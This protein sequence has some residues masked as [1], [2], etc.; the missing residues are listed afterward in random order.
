MRPRTHAIVVL[1]GMLIACGLGMDAMPPADAHEGEPGCPRDLA[2]NPAVVVCEDFE[3][4]S[5]LERWVVGSNTN[6][7]PESEFV[8]CAPG[9]GFKDGCAAWSNY[10]IFDRAWGFWGYDA[11]RRFPP[12]DEF[13]VRWYQYV[14]DP[15]A[16]GT[17]EDKSVLL[18]DPVGWD[19]P[20]TITAYVGTNRDHLPVEPNSGPGIPFVA[21]YQDLDY[22]ETGGEYTKV[23]R[24][25]NQGRNIALESGKWYLFEWYIRLNTPGLSNGVT[26]LW[27]DDATTRI[28]R[29]TLRMQHTDMRWLRASDAGKR[30]GFLRLTVYDQRCDIGV[31]T[32]PPN[33]P[34]ILTQYH[35][36]DDIVVSRKPVGP[37][38]PPAGPLCHAAEAAPTA[39][40]PPDGRLVPVSVNGVTHPNG[41]PV[42]VTI[43]KVTQDEPGGG[44]GRGRGAP[45]AIIQGDRVL[46]RAERAGS[47]DGRVYEVQFAAHDFHGGQCAGQVRVGVPHDAGGGAK[48]GGP[49]YDSTR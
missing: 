9:S 4:G 37:I 2:A 14:S 15:Y 22:P 21:N 23:N 42:T 38:L 10:L 41:D 13:Y 11:W 30:F 33:G 17:L 36:W 29:Q 6:R 3:E 8:T 47:G 25:Q 40:W 7:W 24:F 34:E 18:H 16:W 19:E 45:D 43:L 49:P 1:G 20:V 5:F 32:C 46:L 27:I 35:R 44:P 26:K 12:Q 48:D 31:N 39:L 28:T